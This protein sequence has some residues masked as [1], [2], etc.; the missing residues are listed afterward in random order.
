[1]QECPKCRSQNHRK[2]GRVQGKQR[3]LCKDCGR[4]FLEIEVVTESSTK[5]WEYTEQGISIILLDL[6]NLKLDRLAENYLK[7]LAT[8]PLQV[9]LAF[10]NWSETAVNK[11]DTEFY[12]RGYF[13]VH[14]PGG[15]NSADARMMTLGA[16]LRIHYPQ[17]KEVFVCS[18]DWLLTNLCNELMSQNLRVWRI[19][20]QEKNLEIQNHQTGQVYAYSLEFHQEIPDS[21]QLLASLEELIQKEQQSVTE[22]IQNLYQL[23]VLLNTRKTLLQNQNNSI[24][25]NG[26][27]IKDIPPEQVQVSKGEIIETHKTILSGKDLENAILQIIDEIK[28]NY[29]NPKIT[30]ST[31]SAN[32]KKRFG[33]TANQVVKNLKLGSN[34]T[35]FLENSPNLILNDTKND[36]VSATVETYRTQIRA[37]SSSY[38]EITNS[39]Q[40][41]KILFEL[42]QSFIQKHGE[43]YIPLTTLG[44]NFKEHYGESVSTVIKTLKLKGNFSKFVQSCEEFKVTKVGK[45]YRITPLNHY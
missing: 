23:E 31:I 21:R 30:P 45:V 25:N 1:M 4:Q 13:L 20:R 34:I 39:N 9:K 3:Y 43:N 6:E 40:L 41:R 33:V 17:V 10:A 26:A 7:E 35:D 14:V 18:S 24:S 5:S 37:T 2:N 29:S 38:Q 28:Q 22:K 8:Y 16:A 15:K 36:K 32:F 44:T 42:A 12:E 27:K 11:Q 19:R